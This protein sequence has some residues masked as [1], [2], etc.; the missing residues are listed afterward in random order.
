MQAIQAAMPHNAQR[1]QI[2]NMQSMGGAKD[3]RRQQ[4][5]LRSVGR[6]NY[7]VVEALLNRYYEYLAQNQCDPRGDHLDALIEQVRQDPHVP[8]GVPV[9]SAAQFLIL[10]A[11][12]SKAANRPDRGTQ[13]AETRE[14]LGRVKVVMD[15]IQQIKMRI[16]ATATATT[17]PMRRSKSRRRMED[18][19]DED[20]DEDDEDDEVSA[21]AKRKR[22][23]VSVGPSARTFVDS[24]AHA[25]LQRD[26]QDLKAAVEAVESK[27]EE[28]QRQLGAAI[29]KISGSLTL[30][31][32]AI[33]T[34]A[35]RLHIQLPQN[36]SVAM[37]AAAAAAASVHH[38]T[39]AAADPMHTHGK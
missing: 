28:Q 24:M 38:G 23:T 29:E 10:M 13:T 36:P 35:S 3:E 19:D 5:R 9:P 17:A 1:I 11:N 4:V 20:D 12:K 37:D 6:W 18:G 33:N 34:I 39:Y 25:Q 32:H 21:P 26:I 15:Q 30:A 8:Q 22:T 2:V 7:Q 27:Q 31:T 16:A 14:H